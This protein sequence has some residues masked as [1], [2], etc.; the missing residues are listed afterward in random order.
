MSFNKALND[1][2]VV[3][4]MRKMVA[5]IKQEALEKAREIKVKAD[6]E[7]NIEKAKLVRQE[8]INIDAAFQRKVKQADVQ[9]RIAQSNNINKS[10]MTLLVTRQQMLDDL[11]AESRNQLLEVSKDK[12]RYEKFL[13]DSLVQAFFRLLEPEV[14]V[15]L[16]KA[17]KAVVEGLLPSVQAR[18]EEATKS[19]IKVVIL[20]EYLAADSAG[21]VIVAGN[22]GKTKCNNTPE[23]RLSILE[24]DM[25]PDVRNML[26]GPSPNRKFFN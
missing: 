4:E 24:E 25:L 7:F 17:D 8:S 19:A 6:E 1:D 22:G 26:F 3:S 9:R 11:F 10:R 21:G 12:T 13:A 23:A 16:R 15:Q 20:D 14:T 2:E 5:F 18:Y